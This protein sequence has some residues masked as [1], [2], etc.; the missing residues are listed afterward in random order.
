MKKTTL[1]GLWILV[2]VLVVLATAPTDPNLVTP[3][4]TVH[5]DSPTLTCSGSTDAE[6]NP[7]NY[8]FILNPDN[9]TLA[10][11]YYGSG[12]FITKPNLN[13]WEVDYCDSVGER[14]YFATINNATENTAAQTAANGDN[15]W[16]A[17]V[18]MSGG[19]NFGNLDWQTPV[20]RRYSDYRNWKAGYP[21]GKNHTY[22]VKAD[23]E[24]ITLTQGTARSNLCEYY[25]YGSNITLQNSTSST[26]NIDFVDPEIYGGF[27]YYTW[28]CQ[29]CD[30]NSE[31][32]DISISTFIKGDLSYCS[33]YQID[34]RAMTFTFYNESTSNEKVFTELSSVEIEFESDDDGGSFTPSVDLTDPITSSENYLCLN[35]NNYTFTG[36]GVVKFS[37]DE[38]PTRSYYVSDSWIGNSTTDYALYLLPLPDGIYVTFQ[39]LD[40]GNS[41][42]EDVLVIAQKTIGGSLQQVSGGLTDAAGGI[43]FWLDPEDSHQFTFSKTG[44]S[45]AIQTITPT[46]SSYTITISATAEF[47]ES[48]YN[49]GILYSTT[50][51]D[52]VL[53][54]NTDYSFSFN[55]SSSNFTLDS[56]GFILTNSTG[57]VLT[58]VYGTTG[59]GGYVNQTYNTDSH[60]QIT[61][62]YFWVIDGNNLTSTRTWNVVSTYQG[63]YSFMTFFDDFNS[64]TGSGMSGFTRTLIAFAIILILVSVVSFISG[65]NSP[66]AIISMII[67]LTWFFEYVGLV[68]IIGIKYFTTS[69]MMLLGIGYWIWDNVR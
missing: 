46:Q 30:N 21:D 60:S 54:N 27:G 37:S 64:F 48:N 9:N 42:I 22:I 13:G 39:V 44:Y 14:W 16:I 68:P 55:I 4:G 20:L 53:N 45:T 28:G 52:L 6:G 67:M 5:F 56:Y 1:L 29:A 7:F 31:C 58:S 12:R 24:W 65:V 47:N 26:A 17:L 43:T 34:S 38:M 66:F 11:T 61:M 33:K 49:Q 59:T 35:P 36:S 62:E 15:P 51:T 18:N 50:P 23:G 41:P 19:A 57:D 32:S 2:G 8:Y 25:G 3:N 10:E 40:T 69:M 63:G